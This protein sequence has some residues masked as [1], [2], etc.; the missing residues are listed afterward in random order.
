MACRAH[1]LSFDDVFR[2]DLRPVLARPKLDPQKIFEARRA[3]VGAAVMLTRITAR[4]ISR[5]TGCPCTNVQRAR[6]SFFDL[7]V[8]DKIRALCRVVAWLPVRT[9]S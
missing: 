8:T 9:V 5:L 1:S 7:S 4:D 3:A 2:T 6:D